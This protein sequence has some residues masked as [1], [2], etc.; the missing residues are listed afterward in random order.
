MLSRTLSSV[1]CYFL[2]I[3]PSVDV[4]SDYPSGW[5]PRWG[6]SEMLAVIAD[7]DRYQEQLDGQR[8]T[9]EITDYSGKS[10]QMISAGRSS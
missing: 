9:L 6:Y 1:M 7:G 10:L 4:W 2:V 8:V 5:E 3:L